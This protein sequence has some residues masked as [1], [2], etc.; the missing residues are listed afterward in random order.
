MTEERDAGFTLVEV[1]IALSL[2]G[3]L[4][5][6]SYAA[7]QFGN[8]SWLHVRAHRDRDEDRAAIRR[9]L[10]R[11][12][13]QAYPAFA[14]ADITDQTILFAGGAESLE[15]VAPL[16]EALSPGLMAVER[17]GLSKGT[18]GDTLTM[19]W[20]LDLPAA[21]GGVLPA[22]ETILA[23]GAGAVR[24]SYF[25]R[26]ND[27]QAAQWSDTWQGMDHLPEMVRVQVWQQ[28]VAG[29]PLVDFTVE[30]EATVS[31]SCVY[32]PS[33]IVCRRMQ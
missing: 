6:L 8:L 3:M 14:S 18:G 19:A 31:V 20:R 25:G 33:D 4:T 13:A 24:F 17:F 23:E 2:L 30:T 28:R 16:P 32:D 21:K 26:V 29:V 10:G 15:L 12:I 7:I 11:S 27:Q 9:V 1:L 5:V 22:R